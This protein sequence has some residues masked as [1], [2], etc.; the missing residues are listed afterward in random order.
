MPA[1]LAALPAWLIPALTATGAAATIGTS[2]YELSQGSGAP[3]SSAN[4]QALQAQ[5]QQQA[6]QAAL[7]KQQATNAVTG[8]AQAQTG[9]ALSDQGFQSF[10]DQLAGY[11]GYSPSGTNSAPGSATP[12]AVQ[13]AQTA[14]P[15]GQPNIASI[16]K[17]LGIGGGSNG[18]NISGGNWPADREGLQQFFQLSGPV[19]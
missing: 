14:T 1:L 11:P 10:V 3:S 2:A 5:Q 18:G 6:N 9:G 8:E 7:Q 17:T 16:L 19:T 13:N 4:Q 12:G 15:G